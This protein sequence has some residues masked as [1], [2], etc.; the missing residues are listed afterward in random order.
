MPEPEREQVDFAKEGEGRIICE[1]RYI[2]E[3]QWYKNYEFNSTTGVQQW[4]ETTYKW[5]FD[6]HYVIR[7]RDIDT[8]HVYYLKTPRAITATFRDG[9]TI[10]PVPWT[11]YHSP[12]Q[13]GEAKH[14]I[15]VGIRRIA[16]K[17]SLLINAREFHNELDKIGVAHDGIKY[18]DQPTSAVT[19]ATSGYTMSPVMLLKR[20]YREVEVVEM[21]PAEGGYA[22]ESK[23]VPVTATADLSQV[24]STPPSFQNLK[25]LCDSAHDV[26]RKIFE[27]YQPI[28]I[29]VEIHKKILK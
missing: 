13:T 16:G 1:Y 9:T 17:L 27:H 2:T 23:M 4:A 29:S 25:K 12:N 26:A 21:K 18:L 28:D 20:D 5:S 10:E 3:A 22:K 11:D 19:V 7:I 14:V 15:T 8:E 6:S 24:F